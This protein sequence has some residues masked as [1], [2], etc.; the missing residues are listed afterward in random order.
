MAKMLSQSIR[1]GRPRSVIDIG[2]ARGSLR[3]AVAPMVVKD[4]LVT[5]P[6]R[7]EPGSEDRVV[8][9]EAPVHYEDG[10]ATPSDRVKE[11]GAVYLR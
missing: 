5:V 7:I 11:L 4:E 6:E 2:Q 8:H 1:V 3:P 9:S 10:P